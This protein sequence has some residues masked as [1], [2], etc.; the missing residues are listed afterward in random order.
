MELILCTQPM[1]LVHIDYVVMEVTVAAQE[2][3]VVKNILQ[4]GNG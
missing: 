2:R 1:E 4:V 3:P